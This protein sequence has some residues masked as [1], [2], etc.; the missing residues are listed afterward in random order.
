MPP[1][2]PMFVFWLILL[3]CA[4]MLIAHH[5][6]FPFKIW[7]LSS[8]RQPKVRVLKDDGNIIIK[9]ISVPIADF[10]PAADRFIAI[11]LL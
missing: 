10:R 6:Y 4:V 9:S 7:L 3:P 1:P 8:L 11:G 5:L 2:L